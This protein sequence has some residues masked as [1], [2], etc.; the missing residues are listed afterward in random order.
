MGKCWI[1]AV[2]AHTLPHKKRTWTVTAG[3]N[4]SVNKVRAATPKEPKKDK[5]R[6]KT[7]RAKKR[8]KYSRSSKHNSDR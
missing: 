7:G 8:Q 2:M 4:P 6:E 1:P 5:R 3:F